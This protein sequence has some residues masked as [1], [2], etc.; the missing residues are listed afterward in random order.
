[1]TITPFQLKALQTK[2]LL[3]FEGMQ[4]SY[5]D[6]SSVFTTDVPS[7]TAFNTYAFMGLF[8]QFR[9]WVGARH[10]NELQS[11][12]YTVRNELYEDTV[13]LDTTLIDDGDMATVDLA[14]RGVMSEALQLGYKLAMDALLAGPTTLG[15]DGQFLFDTDHPISLDA[16]SGTQRNYY[17]SGMALT[18]TNFQAR[19]AEMMSFKGDNGK[20]FRTSPTHILVPPQL[21]AT[22]RQILNAEL[23]ATGTAFGTNINRGLAEV[24]VVHEM[25]ASPTMWVL[26]DASKDLKPIV[27]QNREMTPVKIKDEP[28]ERRVLVGAD[29]RIGVGP[30]AWQCAMMCVGLCHALLASPFRR[31][32]FGARAFVGLRMGPLTT[33]P[34]CRRSSSRSSRP[35]LCFTSRSWGRMPPRR[36]P[37]KSSVYASY[38]DFLVHGLPAAML[39]SLG[40]TQLE[41][42]ARL[43]AA[44][45]LL[46]RDIIK[47]NALPLTS[48]DASIT[49]DTC[50]LAAYDTL[51]VVGYNPDGIDANLRARYED[52]VKRYPAIAEGSTPMAPTDGTSAREGAL[53]AASSPPRGW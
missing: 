50:V 1:M 33:G 52:V 24:V 22:A 46:D 23:T 39:A 15:Y 37:R 45:R 47:R 51:S 13:A 4:G 38:A 36:C 26:V 16:T 34:R 49:R 53:E 28:F 18:P 43:E 6:L 10:V 8:P 7:T 5:T 21:E 2:L 19:R 12:A 35:R 30:G 20:S 40:V 9:K 32:V 3:T 11:R 41:T 29:A 42:E 31:A 27:R 25:D 14:T 44:S 48:W 17:A